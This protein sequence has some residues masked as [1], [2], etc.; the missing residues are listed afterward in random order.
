M[1]SR[2]S[3]ALLTLLGV[4]ELSAATPDEYVAVAR[5]CS[6]ELD[7]LAR[8]R[9]NLRGSMAACAISNGCLF[10]PYVESAYREMWQGW[11]AGLPPC[12]FVARLAGEARSSG[13]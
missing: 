7:F 4:E 13:G 11:C 1:Q 8:V 3:T 5:K 10:C 6:L 9:R 12:G 2:V